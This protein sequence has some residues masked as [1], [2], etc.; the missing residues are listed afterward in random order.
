VD[1]RQRRATIGGEFQGGGDVTVAQHV[2]QRL[3]FEPLHDGERRLGGGVLGE[4]SSYGHATVH[5]ADDARFASARRRIGHVD[6]Q[7]H[8]RRSAR[9]GQAIVEVA[10]A[11]CLA[12]SQ[13]DVRP[14]EE[15]A[16]TLLQLFDRDFGERVSP[17]P[18]ALHEQILAHRGAGRGAHLR[19]S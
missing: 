13:Q 8:R 10:K 3:A 18:V 11:T 17:F 19:N 4:H 5:F 16:D 9:H 14:R 1:S 7:G 2:I 15:G 6:T 12:G